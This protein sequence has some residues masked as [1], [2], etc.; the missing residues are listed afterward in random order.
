MD[1]TVKVTML[2][3]NRQFAYLDKSCLNE[4]LMAHKIMNKCF[5]SLLLDKQVQ[6]VA[7]AV[8]VKSVA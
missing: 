7:V 1:D 4:I 6:L 5:S 8:T 2:V 3:S